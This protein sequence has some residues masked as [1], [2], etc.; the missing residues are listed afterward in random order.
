[1]KQN[2]KAVFVFTIERL[3]V[4]FNASYIYLNTMEVKMMVKH[5]WITS[6]AADHKGILWLL[7]MIASRYSL[8]KLMPRNKSSD[9]H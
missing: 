4:G 2:V 8:S 1:M 9:K 6:R 5:N 3:Y 7:G